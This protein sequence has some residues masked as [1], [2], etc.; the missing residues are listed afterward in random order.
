MCWSKLGL[1][2]IG[3]V[4]YSGK[5]QYDIVPGYCVYLVSLVGSSGSTLALL[6]GCE[7]SQITVVIALPT[8][9]VSKDVRVCKIYREINTYILW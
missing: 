3:S 7:L 8:I 2:N 9:I 4:L 1:G 5:H 6:T